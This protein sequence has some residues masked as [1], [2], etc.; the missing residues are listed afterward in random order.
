MT[1]RPER[2]VI[3]G[4]GPAGVRAAEVLAAAG[5]R[6][7]LFDE[8]PAGGGQIYR[9][10]PKELNRAYETLY[11]FEA[12]KARNLHESFARLCDAIDYRP[13]CLVWN[14]EANQLR[15][16]SAGVPD[17][18]AFDRLI[19]ATGAM[20]RVLPFP[21]WTL[22]GV[23]TLGGAQVALKHQAC[24]IGQRTVFFGSSP[25]LPY[26][27]YQY[28][29][30]G[31]QVV[32]VF[33]IAPRGAKLRA[34]PNLLRGGATGF[35][36]AYYMAWLHAKGIAYRHGIS[37]LGAEGTDAV[38]GFRYLD[39]QGREET[40]ACDAI[41]FGYGLKSE[42]QLADLAGCSLTFDARAH[43]WRIETDNAGRTSVPGVYAAGDGASIAGA[44]AAELSG[45][46]AAHALLEDL[47]RADQTARIDA[48]NKRLGRLRPLRA[49]LE[50]AFPFP[51]HLAQRLAD[52]QVV[53]RCEVVTAGEIRHAVRA[54]GADDINRAKAFCRV[55]MGRCQGRVCE[56]AA[57]E[58]VANALN[59]EVAAVGRFRAQAPIK[60]VPV[61]AMAEKRVEALA[62]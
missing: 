34:L 37:P 28:A 43:T 44:D 31:A 5:L 59:R 11:G 4:A 23:Y 62:S 58:I 45:A 60:P 49:G 16:L 46:R 53:C 9:Q 8:A 56:A 48:L 29:K 50:T 22:P 27:A 3:V 41:A 18:L 14:L 21:G 13:D 30:T 32:G 35:K 24:A 20:D 1:E 55:G 33:D 7:C 15:L 61:L 19:L 10:Q 38:E 57:A 47:G 17:T 39:A 36:G 26:V 2:I 42:L 52:D 25:L 54:L 40:L 12:S 6:P 51:R